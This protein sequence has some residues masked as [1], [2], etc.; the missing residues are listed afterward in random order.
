[1]DLTLK[2]DA[3]FGET[4]FEGG[5]ERGRH[6][7][8]CKPHA[9]HPRREPTVRDGYGGC[10]HGPGSSSGFDHDGGD[11]ETGTGVELG[12]AGVVQAPGLRA[13]RRGERSHAHRTRGLGVRGVGVRGVGGKRVGPSCSP[14]ASGRGLS[15][16][17]ALTWGTPS[18]GAERL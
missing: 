9:A 18:S 1:M 12:G 11:A 14:G 5:L 3:F 16:R 15:F 7:G 2:A 8:G 17:L 4:T 10:P 13:E 6:D